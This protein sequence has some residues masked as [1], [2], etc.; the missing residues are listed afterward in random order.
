MQRSYRLKILLCGPIHKVMLACFKTSPLHGT[1]V[2]NGDGVSKAR[3]AMYP[4]PL[5]KTTY[6]T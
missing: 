1:H 2:Q 3:M 5:T 6:S 4:E